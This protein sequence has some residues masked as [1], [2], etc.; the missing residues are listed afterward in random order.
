MA[1][2]EILDKLVNG[3]FEYENEK[4]SFSV[5]KIEASMPS[6]ELYEGTFTLNSIS[7]E[8]VKGEIYSSSMRV[9]VRNDHF[10]AAEEEIDYIF[11][12]TGLEA[13]DIIKGDFHVV[14]E[15]GEYHIPFVFSIIHSVIKSSLGNVRNLFHFTN[16]AQSNWNEA[17]SL[18][19]SPE[20][21]QVFDGN[22][23]I[24]LNKYRGLSNL[25]GNEQSVDEFLV[26]IN[27]K[28]PIIYSVEKNVYEFRELTEEI[29][30]ELFVHKSTW[31]YVNLDVS[32]D[33]T[34]IR[35]AKDVIRNEDF[36]GNE[37]L[38][39]FTIND[40]L[41]HEG[42]NFGTI[43]IRSSSQE[44]KVVIIASGRKNTDASKYEKREKNKLLARLMYLYVSFRMKQIN[45]NSWVRESMK[46][47]ERMNALDDKNP[48]SRLYQTQL[49]IVQDRYNEAGWIL[50]HV[51]AEMN[52]QD[53]DEEVYCY[54]L[55]LM[56]LYRRN[57]DY[58]N[59]VSDQIADIVKHKP[60]DFKL[61]WP[62]LYLDEELSR[63]TARKIS[64]LE[65]HFN[66]GCKSPILYIEAYNY[67]TFN[68]ASFNKIT[69]FEIQIMLFAIKYKHI[70][71]DILK[72]FMYL[73]G[74]YKGYSQRIVDILIA[75]YNITEDREVVDVLC[76]ILIRANKTDSK[77]FKWFRLGV[78]NNLRI[79][80]LYEY[81]MYSIPLDYADP[82]PKTVIMYFGFRN[83]LGYERLAFMYSN[84]IRFKKT[85]MELYETYKENM[86]VFAVEQ[87][88]EEHINANLALI[89]DDVLFNEMIR[90]DMAINLS[91]LL[92]AYDVYVDNKDIKAV[93][94]L[95]NQIEEERSYPV[96][97]NHAYPVIYNEESVVFFE[98][99]Y[100]RRSVVKNELIHKL[101]NKT[102]FIPAI[103]HYVSENI[104]FDIFICEGKRHYIV[105]EDDN[106]ELCREIVESSIVRESY[107]RDIRM[108]LVRYYY[109]NDQVT[110]LDEF[111]VNIDARKLISKDRA[112][113]IN[114][115]VKRG[116]YDN[117][118]EWVSIY[119]MEELPAKSCVKICSYI[120]DKKDRL[121][122][123]LLLK[124]TYQAFKMGKYDETTLKYL[125]ANYRGL[126]KE[127]RDIWRAAREFDIDSYSLMERLLIQ[128][129]YTRTTVGE[130]ME[131]FE[132]YLKSGANTKVELAFLSYNAYEYFAKDRVV[133][134]SLWGY[135]ISNYRMGEELNDAL[136]LA[137]LKYYAEEEKNR[138]ERV[139]E[140]LIDFI[141]D[142]LH[143]NI[144]FKMF[145]E[146]IDLVPELSAYEDKVIIEYRTN[147]SNRVVLHYILE[148]MDDDNYHTE[149][150]R[151][152]FG[153]VFS[154]EFILFF[155]ENLQYYI[156][157]EK[158]GREQLTF[159]DS[160]SI[161]DSVGDGTESRYTLLNDMVVS[162]TLQDNDTLL[163]L[164][165][166]YV[167]ADDFT[168]NI[169]TVI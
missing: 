155:G 160:I 94:V 5:S 149:E 85:Q 158:N 161:A 152:M 9:V 13:G 121:P 81:Y 93:I 11:D 4:L 137:L 10:D 133:D 20:F 21:I 56:T 52:I 36:L 106:V 148:G 44:I 31:G 111:I 103:K 150:M 53:A 83:D 24:H 14:S 47:V 167:E 132:S 7:G 30:C 33:C 130:K 140:M 17:V 61:L 102:R 117:A 95:Q 141:K 122:D 6:G 125:V 126:T 22:D 136:K 66:N 16:Q 164:M 163:K 72:Q 138:S 34:F 166:E 37:H 38:L 15:A 76:S 87:I 19:Y 129:M 146:F 143:R 99:A 50:E 65:K 39:E 98:D 45:V 64:L 112:E 80:R 73:A 110:A 25:K 135:I 42:D 28:S 108:G 67:F 118:Y 89:Y 62:L 134:D 2:R 131:I 156:T 40:E 100:G 97:N 124:I 101:M 57:E 107:K 115:F 96:I 51:E 3:F 168:A 1:L 151:D 63:N 142:Y 70:D 69:E 154:K 92:F 58:V 145:N 159:S 147:P 116:M 165:E 60:D 26:S 55:Y 49:L 157:E 8:N 78:E 169:F 162:R 90:P 29:K 79:T 74:R 120:I 104:Y 139:K 43:T 144:Y 75:A 114:Y 82:L 91:R 109:D 105:V 119:G 71:S 123:V 86:L 41:L 84:L 35:L 77:Y 128:M 54:Y 32:T 59:Q 68:P 12:P 127:L 153:G 23:R 46:V 27:K 18:F 88:H 113:V 48:V